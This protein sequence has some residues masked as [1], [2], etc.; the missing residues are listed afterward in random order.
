MVD[1]FLP[2]VRDQRS[3]LLPAWEDWLLEGIWPGS[4]SMRGPKGEHNE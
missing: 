1:N 2:S 3:L 4:S